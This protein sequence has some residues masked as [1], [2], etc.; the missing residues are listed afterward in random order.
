MR[1]TCAVF[2]VYRPTD[3]YLPGYDYRQ[4]K[5][6][7]RLLSNIHITSDTAPLFV[8]FRRVW[9]YIEVL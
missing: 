2:P 5:W 8:A 3:N 9:W 6:F 4:V 1:G 7:N